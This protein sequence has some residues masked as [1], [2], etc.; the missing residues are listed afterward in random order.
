[1]TIK[2]VA[3]EAGVST[4]TVSR[5]LNNTG[6]VQDEKREQI[7]R[8]INKL[9]YKPSSRQ[10]IRSS[11]VAPL[12]H[13]NIALIWTGYTNAA[14]SETGQKMV[15]GILNSLQPLG[16]NLSV[17]HITDPN[18]IPQCLIDGKIDGVLLHGPKPSPAICARL[19]KVPAVWLLQ[20]GS[21]QFGDHVQPD[22]NL[23]GRL[24]ARHL[25]Q[26]GSKQLCCI[27]YTPEQFE[28]LYWQSRAAGFETLAKVQGVNCSVLHCPENPEVPKEDRAKQ[29]VD[30]FEQLT[31]RPDALFVA[32]DLGNPVHSELMRRGITPMEDLPMI[33]G[34]T[35]V[36]PKPLDFECFH[37]EIGQLAVEAL[38]WRIKNPS[39]PIVTHSIKPELIL[40]K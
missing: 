10:Q 27:S 32:N 34:N 2:K 18:R 25:I 40:P 4:A 28:P 38:L 15:L 24:A 12:K 6:V 37:Q 9:G 13:R 8:A 29:L 11:N 36:T 14:F 7:L 1:M 20:S 23:I 16:A 33:A 35:S 21:T 17:D 5:V 22:H 30:S 39:M 26:Q 3:L 31:P 19:R